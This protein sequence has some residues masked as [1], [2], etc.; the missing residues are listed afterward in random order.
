VGGDGYPKPIWDKLTGK[1][2]HSVAEYWRENYDLSYIL[3]RDWK[4]LGPKLK[5]KIH[6]YCGDMD[7]YYLNNAVYLIE[8]F[9]ESTKDPYYEGEVDYGD[10]AEHCWNGDHD[11]PNAISRLRYH[12]MFIPRIVERIKKSAPPGADLTSWRYKK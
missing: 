6:I 10:R 7:N 12:Q 5:G 4:T 8:E 3:Q 2:D 9:L 11:R 1:I